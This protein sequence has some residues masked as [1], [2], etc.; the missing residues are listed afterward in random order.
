MDFPQLSKK[1]YVANAALVAIGMAGVWYGEAIHR[2]ARSLL[3]ENPNGKSQMNSLTASPRIT[4][5]G[6]HSATAE[7]CA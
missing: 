1:R 7:Q 3:G 2:S 6:L 4:V 5:L